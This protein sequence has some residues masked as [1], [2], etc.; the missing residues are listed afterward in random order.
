MRADARISDDAD[1][2]PGNI[3]GVFCFTVSVQ[4]T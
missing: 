4:R 2:N 1:E 3:P